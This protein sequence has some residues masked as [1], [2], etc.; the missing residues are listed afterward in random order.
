MN[1]WNYTLNYYN[2]DV[3]FE[4]ID[5]QEFH[6]SG[7]HL[8]FD[9]KR[10]LTNDWRQI[11]GIEFYSADTIINDESLSQNYLIFNTKAELTKDVNLNLYGTYLLNLD[12][13]SS[14]WKLAFDCTHEQPLSSSNK[15]I[16]SA[17]AG[18]SSKDTPLNLQFNGG[19]FNLLPLRGSAS[20]LRGFNYGIINLEFHQLLTAG[21]W[22]IAFSD[23]GQFWDDQSLADID[24]E[25]NLGV[26]VAYDPSLGFVI[27][28]D[29][30]KSLK[31]DN[32]GWNIGIGHSF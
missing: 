19:G 23:F 27:R 1:G 13:D 3:E 29:F 28:L 18:V 22:G 2:F 9:S 6:A 26:G 21:F 5:Q 8:V 12:G 30:A 14:S 25:K 10:Y 31:D 16:I 20:N 32:F 11:I 4:F 17:K 15:F 24:W 7:H